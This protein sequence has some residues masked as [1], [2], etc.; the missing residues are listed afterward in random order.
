[1]E[2]ADLCLGRTGRSLRHSLC[3]FETYRP[4]QII[5]TPEL[6]ALEDNSQSIISECMAVSFRMKNSPPEYIDTF[7]VGCK[8]LIFQN[9]KKSSTYVAKQI[10]TTWDLYSKIPHAGR[11]ALRKIIAGGYI[12][13]HSGPHMGE[14]PCYRAHFTIQS[15]E[16][17]FM[18]VGGV[19]LNWVPGKWL[20]FDDN[21][22]HSAYNNG[23]SDRIVLVTSL[24]KSHYRLT[25][26]TIEYKL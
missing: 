13:A 12:M 24:P 10:P 7:S 6:K 1:V 20:F 25:N 5:M 11:T 3:R 9:M 23:N 14:E 22:E 16:D 17:A 18:L 21:V 19:R 26:N 15:N 2:L 4:Y 8:E